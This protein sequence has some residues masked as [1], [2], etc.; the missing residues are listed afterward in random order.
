[1]SLYNEKVKASIFLLSY[2]DTL[3]FYNKF[4][5][6]NMGNQYIPDEEFASQIWLNIIHNFFALGGF[7]NIDLTDWNCSDDTILT[8][9]TGI[10]CLNG[11]TEK[12]YIDEFLKALPILKD[13]TKDR[14]PGLAT[15]DSLEL[16]KRF[17][18]LEKLDYDSSLGGNGAAMRTSIIGLIYYK[19]SDLEKLIENSILSS[20]ITHNY[21]I[22]FLGGFVTALFTSYAIRDIPV[23]EWVDKLLELYESKI[24]DNY[25]KKTNI[26]KK[27]VKD[28]E[29]FFDN[30]YQYKEQTLSKF[31]ENHREFEIYSDRINYL[32]PYNDL[33]KNKNFFKFGV[34]GISA[35]IVAYDSL[36]MSYRGNE[37]PLDLNKK[38]LK[39]S[40]DSLIFFSTLHFGDNDT[41]GAIAGAWYGAIFGFK[42]FDQNKLNQLEMK[43]ELQKITDRVISYNNL[44]K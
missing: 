10:A 43:D 35:L 38:D 20:R 5:E 1:M 23:W 3:G 28:N 15:I 19:E 26:Y 6:F 11:G 16:I 14:M 17:K 40:V 22:G 24:L 33:G 13:N 42:H 4:W 7:S 21:S 36:L 37:F 2:F 25:M 29:K 34:S 30:W 44:S 12:D 27:Y 39:F 8:I 31:K 18:K 41:T 9:S 32:L